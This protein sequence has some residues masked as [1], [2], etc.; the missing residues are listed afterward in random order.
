MGKKKSLTNREQL[1]QLR[2]PDI[3][4]TIW[5]RS[6]GKRERTASEFRRMVKQRKGTIISTWNDS[7]N[8]YECAKE[9]LCKLKET[10]EG[11]DYAAFSKAFWEVRKAMKFQGYLQLSL[12]FCE[13]TINVLSDEEVNRE[14]LLEA[15]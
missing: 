8:K 7:Y 12:V 6:E 10:I 13:E 3:Y 15:I 2:L 11:N 1:L 5:T 14:I 9:S 4:S